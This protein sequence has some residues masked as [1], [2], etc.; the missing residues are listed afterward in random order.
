MV[1]HNVFLTACHV[2]LTSLTTKDEKKIENAYRIINELHSELPSFEQCMQDSFTADDLYNYAMYTFAE[3]ELAIYHQN[4]KLATRH[5]MGIITVAEI[6][7]KK[8]PNCPNQ[9]TWL[10]HNLHRR[11]GVRYWEYFKKM[12]KPQQEVCTCALCKDHEPDQTGSHLVPELLLK[13]WFPRWKELAI[14]ENLAKGESYGYVGRDLASHIEEIRGHEMRDEERDMENS[15]PNPIVRDYLFCRRCE[16][17]FSH[18]E[19]LMFETHKKQLAKQPYDPKIPY[20]FWL[21]IIWRMSVGKMSIHLSSEVEE[22]IRQILDSSLPADEKDDFHW[23][24]VET[25]F[26]YGVACAKDVRGE[27]MGITG[28]H[29]DVSPKVM[30]I[31]NLIL[32]FFE[33]DKLVEEFRKIDPYL[34]LNNGTALE[35]YDNLDFKIY[36][37]RRQFIAMHNAEYDAKHIG[38][39]DL[40]DVYAPHPSIHHRRYLSDKDCRIDPGDYASLR[41]IIPFPIP[42]SLRDIWDKIPTMN[43][44]DCAKLAEGTE[45]SADEM[46]F[47]L[48]QYAFRQKELIDHVLAYYKE[49]G[50]DPKKLAFVPRI[51]R[52]E[53]GTNYILFNPHVDYEEFQMKI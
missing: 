53:D 18:I 7:Y 12:G 22:H 2:A 45:Y 40:M 38:E 36:W 35:L 51:V 10:I 27:A 3:M 13:N 42:W 31:G 34:R 43:E 33:N 19:N 15:L 29:S 24:N 9:T 52:K 6:C 50:L 14:A 1:E 28:T 26:Y 49:T 23:E 4:F 44:L 17:R 39:S 20:L 25:C 11:A 47:M 5:L 8:Y 16:K 48:R 21:S 41:G 30:A 32:T 46:E 37:D